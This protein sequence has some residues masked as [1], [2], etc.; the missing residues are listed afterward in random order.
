MLI[1]LSCIQKG[2]KASFKHL[3]MKKVV[4]K[5]P[6]IPGYTPFEYL[7]V[8]MPH[9]ELRNRIAG[10]KKEF[11]EKYKTNVFRGS[12]SYLTLVK[13]SQFQ[14]V[15]ERLINRLKTIAIGHAAFKVE[16]KGFSSYPCHSIYIPVTSRLQI[17][18]LM[19]DLHAAGKL[20]KQGDKEPF[21]L[22]DPQFTIAN[23]LLPW[24]YEQGWLEYSHRSFTAKFIADH[25]LLLRRRSGEKRYDVIQRFE[26]MNLPVS[27]R[28]GELFWAGII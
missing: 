22:E 23:K 12:G 20:M 27:S 11:S 1:F 25:L 13:F 16:L 17:N 8:L 6:T 14:S 7:L 10:I 26:F 21:Y 18:A 24:Q 9:E 3:N 2:N 15:E 28:Q 5:E 4:K 19:K